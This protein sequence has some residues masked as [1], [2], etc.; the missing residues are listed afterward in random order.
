MIFQFKL[1]KFY[2]LFSR[3][4]RPTKI[5]KVAVFTFFAI[6]FFFIDAS[7]AYAEPVGPK[8][9]GGLQ[10]GADVNSPELKAEL[11]CSNRSPIPLSLEL[12][13]SLPLYCTAL[14]DPPRK[15]LGLQPQKLLVKASSAG[16]LNE[17]EVI[18]LPEQFDLL[19][20]TLI[21]HFGIGYTVSPPSANLRKELRWAY[22][23]GQAGLAMFRD[24]NGKDSVS[25]ELSGM[26]LK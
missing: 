3:Y 26:E 21:K 12:Q 16:V 18:F 4:S 25:V 23:N 20:T 7:I 14:S 6:S 1:L 2:I 5:L 15:I 22:K 10:I 9:D 8:L 19:R 17:I 13:K 11:E 24:G